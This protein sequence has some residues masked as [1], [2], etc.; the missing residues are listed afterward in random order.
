MHKLIDIV[1]ITQNN[2]NL[3]RN[4]NLAMPVIFK[5]NKGISVL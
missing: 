1:F 2:C 4:K 5:L 3:V